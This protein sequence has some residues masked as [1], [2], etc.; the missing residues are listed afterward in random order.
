MQESNREDIDRI[1]NCTTNYLKFCM[2]N[3]IPVKTV[4]CFPNNKLWIT[5]NVKDLLNQKKKAFL[6]RDRELLRQT[7]GGLKCQLREAKEEYRRKV[8]GR[9][10]QNTTR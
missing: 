10:Q 9:I 8:E 6:S 3:V 1:T 2:E 5:S 7:Q 4:H